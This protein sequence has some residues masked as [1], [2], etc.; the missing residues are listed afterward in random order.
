[1]PMNYSK[2]NKFQANKKKLKEKSTNETRKAAEKKVK[3]KVVKA[4]SKFKKDVAAVGKK[5]TGFL[6]KFFNKKK[7]KK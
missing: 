6:N 1:M 7:K 5:T 4:G 2:N 3:G